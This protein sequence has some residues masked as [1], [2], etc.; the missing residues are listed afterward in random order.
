[1]TSRYLK[2]DGCGAVIDRRPAPDIAT[3]RGL[4]P[5]RDLAAIRATQGHF[6][7]F[8]I[9]KINDVNPKR[10]RVY[11]ETGDS[12]GGRA[13]YAKSGKSCFHPTGQSALVVPTAD[14]M[15]YAE[16][17]CDGLYVSPH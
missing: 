8:K 5:D 4:L 15:A 16:K 2:C 6:L 10:G 9:D 12:W 11:L 3:D 17:Y 13:Y 14:V 7:G 1:M